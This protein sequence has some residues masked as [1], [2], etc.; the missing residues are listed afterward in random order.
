LDANETIIDWM[1]TNDDLPNPKN[2]IHIVDDNKKEW[3]MLEGY[4]QW[5]EK[6]P[7]EYKKYDIPLRETWYMVKS[8]IIRKKDAK[9]FYNKLIEIS[10]NENFYNERL[11]QSHEFY[12]I[13]LGEYPNSIAFE[14]LRGNYNIWRKSDE[15][16]QIPVVVTDDTYLNEFTLDCSHSGSVSVKLPCKW[17]V[18][19]MGLHHKHL[20]GR[21]FDKDNNLIT[22]AT[23]IFEENLPST[24]LIDKQALI[25]FLD[26]NGYAIFWTLLGEKQ[27]IGGSLSRKDFVG[28][29]EIGGAYTLKNR[30]KIIG[31]SHSK[32][33]N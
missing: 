2:I 9:K 15:T 25:N 12:E 28:R 17:L 5:E 19:N 31:E 8:Y 24:L 21:F 20:D 32:F 14:D 13:F 26:K 16:V 27:L 11:P 23:S 10:K 18:N 3:L 33:K 1:Q 6:T 30:E 7:P 22:L 4:V 29:L